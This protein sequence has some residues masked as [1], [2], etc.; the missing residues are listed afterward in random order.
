MYFSAPPKVYLLVNCLLRAGCKVTEVYNTDVASV[1]PVHAILKFKKS[2]LLPKDQ[3]NCHR[4]LSYQIGRRNC[5]RGVCVF[6]AQLGFNLIYGNYTSFCSQQ[7]DLRL[8]N[9]L[10]NNFP[11][12]LTPYFT[13]CYMHI[14]Q[15]KHILAHQLRNNPRGWGV[16][17]VRILRCFV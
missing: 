7:W 2:Q 1:K 17:R 6:C 5:G 4:I 14:L 9:F 16:L 8:S 13:S 12:F 15:W 11:Y 3:D 10:W